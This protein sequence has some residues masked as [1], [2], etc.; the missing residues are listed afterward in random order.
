MEREIWIDYAKAIGIILVV[1]GHI[2]EVPDVLIKIIYSFH[3]PLFFFISGY[4]YRRYDLRRFTKVT[5]KLLFRYVIYSVVFALSFLLMNGDQISI[6]NIAHSMLIGY[7]EAGNPAGTLW[8]LL[9]LYMTTIF[10]IVIDNISYKK[11]VYIISMLF[12]ISGFV[13]CNYDIH[14]PL[15]IQTSFVCILFFASGVLFRENENYKKLRILV[16]AFVTV[17]VLALLNSRVDLASDKIGKIIY[18]IVGAM[19]GIYV[20]IE[21]SKQLPKLDILSII[22]RNSITIYLFHIYPG[23]ILR[24]GLNAIGVHGVIG[25]LISYSFT[26]MIIAL[27]IYM[28]ENGR[29]LEGWK[30]TG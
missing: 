30:K 19:A 11:I 12:A 21:I 10:Y 27:V 16:L 14:L 13:I 25:K 23:M 26:W 1:V 15:R 17:I 28:K 20:V 22:G 18:F 5:Q 7:F 29:R 9:T 4:V 3:M 8:F 2:G 6:S 24:V